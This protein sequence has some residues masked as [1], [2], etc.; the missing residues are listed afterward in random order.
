MDAAELRIALHGPKSRRPHGAGTRLDP[1]PK[2]NFAP[3]PADLPVLA[4]TL[5]SAGFATA[6]LVENPFLHRGFG[7]AR[8]FETYRYLFRGFEAPPRADRMVEAALRWL[9]AR[10]QRPFLLV[11]HLMAPHLPYDPPP[12]RARTLHGGLRGGRCAC[13]SRASV[14]RFRRR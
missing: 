10:D 4:E 8:G 14:R 11:L 2:P 1:G 3:L 12:G 9:S 7:V 13:P 5:R 6:A